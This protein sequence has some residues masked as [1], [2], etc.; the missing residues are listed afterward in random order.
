MSSSDQILSEFDPLKGSELQAQTDTVG[1]DKSLSTNSTATATADD[2]QASLSPNPDSGAKATPTPLPNIGQTT[3]LQSAAT[4]AASE[5]TTSSSNNHTSQSPPTNEVITTPTGTGGSSNVTTPPQPNL[6]TADTVM[7]PPQSATPSES[8][9]ATSGHV[10][11]TPQGTSVGV[12]QLDNSLSSSSS[13]RKKK[14]KKKKHKRQSTNPIASKVPTM[15]PVSLMSSEQ[16]SSEMNQIDQFLQSLKMGTF[17]PTTTAA[18]IEKPTL[19]KVGVAPGHE[20]VGVARAQSGSLGMQ[21][22][23]QL[24]SSSSSDSD[25]SSSDSSEDDEG[26]MVIIE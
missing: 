1:I 10:T 21:L 22:I 26:G 15:T 23:G 11:Q 16:I 2:T 20:G 9:P 19:G 5:P 25:E 8:T 17:D 24:E 14:K 6:T 7:S 12:V 18:Q 4:T 13:Q 3:P